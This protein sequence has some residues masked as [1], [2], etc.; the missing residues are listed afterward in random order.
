MDDQEFM[1]LAIIEAKKALLQHE[2]PIGCVIV[3]KNEVIASAFNRKEQ[4]QCATA[5][6]EVLAI[7]QACKKL[8]SW[9]L[10]DCVLYVTLEP[11]LM[12]AGAIYQSRIKR[13]V[14]GAYDPKGG[15]YGSNFDMNAI[16]RL[17]HYPVITGG[18]CQQTCG[19]MLKDFFKG[20]RQKNM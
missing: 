20:K 3:Y 6:A 7:E 18:I 11:C 4:L 10:D 8:N 17:N 14:F 16:P 12:C 13:V 19:E 5:H 15:A 2:V 9:H 1:E